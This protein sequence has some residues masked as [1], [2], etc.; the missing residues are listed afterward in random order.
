[1]CCISNECHCN[2]F[3]NSTAT[4]DGTAIA[5]AV[6]TKLAND[7]V[8]TLFSTHYHTLVES[9]QHLPMIQLGHMVRPFSIILK[10][11]SNI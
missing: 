11:F 5:H 1:M 3:L 10:I 8:R 2:L 9:I 6:A 7:G 4:Y